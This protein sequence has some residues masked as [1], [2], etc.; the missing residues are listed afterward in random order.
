[1]KNNG[2][3]YISPVA[4]FTIVFLVAINIH[5]SEAK[6]SM[7]QIKNMMKPVSK[8]CITKIGVSKDLIDKTHEGEFP[9]DPQLQ[10]YYACI[11]KMMKVVTKDE[12]VDLNLILKQ[13]NMLALEELGKQITPIVQDCDAKITATEVCEVSW[14]FA[15]CL[16]E[17]DQSMYFFP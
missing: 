4:L 3:R 13:I 8:T 6:M 12:Q 11:F 14:A 7:A 10:C 9:P 5:D 17:T 1:M 16:W 15:K 2:M